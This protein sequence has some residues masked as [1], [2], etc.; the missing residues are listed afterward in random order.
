MKMSQKVASIYFATAAVAIVGGGGTMAYTTNKAG[1]EL[2]SDYAQAATCELKLAKKEICTP[3]EMI[4]V[5]KK[6]SNEEFKSYGTT[7]VTTGAVMAIL[8]IL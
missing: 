6:K 8:G 3:A 4:S 2:A 5:E 1:G 7:T